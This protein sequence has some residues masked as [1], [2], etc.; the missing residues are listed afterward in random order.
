VDELQRSHRFTMGVLVSVLILSL[1]TSG[2]LIFVSQPRLASYLELTRQARDAHEG[3]L[4]QETGLRAWLATGD[5][6]F[7]EP[8]V[9]GRD[10]TQVAVTK[11]LADVQQTP[12]VTDKVLRMLLTRQRWEGWATRAAVLR[13]TN[14]QRTDGTLTRFL[15]QG[16]TLFDTYRQADTSSTGLIR[17]RRSQA[18]ATQTTTLVL[19]FLSY[20]VLLVVAG[21]V[22]VR[23]RRRLQ[24]T[25]LGP[26]ENLHDTVIALRSGRLSARAEPTAVP[27]LEEIGAAL[28]GL[29]SDLTRARADATT[30]ERRLAKLAY[31][32]ETVVRVGREIAGSLSVRYV[33]A[34][35]TTAAADLLDTKAVLWLRGEHQTFQAV[36]RSDDAH[37]AVP[38]AD[39]PPP[40]IV[41]RAAAEAQTVSDDTSS[42]YPLV[43][44]GLVTAVLEVATSQVDPD[45]DQVLTSLL[46]T[47]AAALE[48]AHLHSTA[49][50]QADLDGLTH[51]PNRRRFE[52]DVDTEWERCRRYGR[53]LSLVMM[54][55]DH[56]KRLNDD[57][58]HLLGDQVLREVAN[59]VVAALRSTDTAYRY[60][61]EELVVLL[62]ETGLEDASAVAER[63]RLAVAGVA[64][65]EHPR[66]SVSASVG[67]ATRH[68][69][70]AHYTELVARADGA[71]YEAKRLGRDR[72]V[73]TPGG[74]GETLFHGE[75]GEA[76]VRDDPTGDSG[77]P[78]PLEDRVQV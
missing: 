65:T 29:A 15:L 76:G 71:L 36:Q 40:A 12:D 24:G 45:T 8:Y 70:M 52:V 53:P 26:I 20:L 28:G 54:D 42:A 14:R 21:T 33:S 57:H 2:Y 34:T 22:T 10:D 75:A 23:R 55:L 61:G 67:V 77:D 43:L 63:L 66:L 7:L 50:E 73:T 13:F 31:R 69:A 30:R 39:L 18:L 17:A 32:F 4:N 47:A 6:Q 3:M 68:A 74:G 60:G 62:R 58:G 78:G 72:V 5:Q 9:T 1:A 25:V 44:A 41:A 56:F 49:R 16:K 38:P 59:A 19:V 64:L 35:V 51:L 27:E 48:S 11:L 46:S 37:G